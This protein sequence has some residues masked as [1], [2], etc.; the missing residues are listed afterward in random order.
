MQNMHRVLWKR[1]PYVRHASGDA[2]NVKPYIHLAK[3][4]MHDDDDDDCWELSI[5]PQS[6]T[7]NLPRID[8][9]VE[10]GRMIVPIEAAPHEL[11]HRSKGDSAKDPLVDRGANDSTSYCVEC[12]EAKKK[13]RRAKPKKKPRHS[14]P[15]QR[16]G[17]APK[18]SRGAVDTRRLAFQSVLKRYRRPALFALLGLTA[19]LVVAL[20]PVDHGI[21]LQQLLLS[22]PALPPSS[23]LR[24]PPMLPPP[25]SPL[26]IAPPA[27]PPPAAP[28]PPKPAPPPLPPPQ[29]L[30]ELR[31]RLARLSVRMLPGGD[32]SQDAS[33]SVSPL[34]SIDGVCEV[35]DAALALGGATAVLQLVNRD[36][37]YHA[38]VSA[39]AESERASELEVRVAPEGGW[40]LTYHRAGSGGTRDVNGQTIAEVAAKVWLGDGAQ[41]RLVTMATLSWLHGGVW[42]LR[43]YAGVFLAQRVLEGFRIP[44]LPASDDA[45][46]EL[47][48]WLQKPATYQL[49]WSDFALIASLHGAI[50]QTI[51]NLTRVGD[52]S[53]LSYPAVLAQRWCPDG[54][55]NVYECRHGVGHGIFYTIIMRRPELAGYSLCQ[56]LRPFTLATISPSEWETSEAICAEA[57]A[58]QTS[59]RTFT[60]GHGCRSG[61]GHSHW[62]FEPTLAA[63]GVAASEAGL[64]QGM[65]DSG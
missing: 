34:V 30:P 37:F 9:D 58:L 25:P 10:P 46:T 47:I 43:H 57:D 22:S 51:A 52:S 33:G 65:T 6:T 61:F 8:D 5:V 45:A 15:E 17:A 64:V 4:Q 13:A 48:L 63:Y 20:V 41:L 1:R 18:S 55:I 24:P 29:T 12:S 28:P 42:W 44:E 54:V 49:L 16:G 19:L 3:I 53:M 59:Q 38:T 14:L 27:T 21:T 32:A 26:P 35:F 50:L 62:L 56:Q 2:L 36:A 7:R 60:F 39:I 11:G 40:G 23:P 31:L